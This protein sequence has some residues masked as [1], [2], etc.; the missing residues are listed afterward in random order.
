MAYQ[1]IIAA[2]VM[3]IMAYQLNIYVAGIISGWQLSRRLMHI[4]QWR[5][6]WLAAAAN[7]G[8]KWRNGNESYQLHQ[9]MRSVS[10]IMAQWR[11]NGVSAA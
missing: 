5:K 4:A 6:A 7:N 9:R 1:P 3:S 10:E 8:V 11:R 2:S